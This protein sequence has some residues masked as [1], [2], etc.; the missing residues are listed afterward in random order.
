MSTTATTTSSYQ[1]LAKYYDLMYAW[2]NYRREATQVAE[3][4]NTYK[5]SNGKVLLE[6]ACGTGQYL[7]FLQKQFLVTGL[8]ISP[9][10]LTIAKS[11]LPYLNFL[12]DNMVSFQT[13]QSFDVI[14]CLFSSIAYTK[15]YKELRQTLENFYAHLSTGGVIIFDLFV[16][17]DKFVDGLLFSLNIDEPDIKISRHNI[18]K[19]KGELATFD[20]HTL[21]TT[22]YG[23]EYFTEY[24][25]LALF[26]DDKVIDILETVG[27]KAHK[28]AM[29]L[30]KD[31]SLFVGIKKP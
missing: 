1:K 16:Q 18:S 5:K 15:T 13:N 22:H 24:H 25:E 19:R 27:F 21:V 14:L 23:V 6:V 26:E 17:P 20:F 8:D 7:S 2:K 9:E 29:T 10:M 4:I 12:Q 31:R 30:V 11:R 3:L 28:P